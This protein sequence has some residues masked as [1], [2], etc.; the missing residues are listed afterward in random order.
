M[1]VKSR[2]SHFE[3]GAILLLTLV[4]TITPMIGPW[5]RLY[6]VVPICLLR[7]LLEYVTHQLGHPFHFLLINVWRYLTKVS[8]TL[9]RKKYILRNTVFGSGVF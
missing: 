7:H 9:V 5:Q 6:I 3:V 8:A 1:E 2:G 4:S